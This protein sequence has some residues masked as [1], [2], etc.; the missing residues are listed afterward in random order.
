MIIQIN[1]SWNFA[2]KNWHYAA[3]ILNRARISGFTYFL[4]KPAPIGACFS[5]LY[6][7]QFCITQKSLDSERSWHIQ[8]ETMLS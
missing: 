4:L 8:Y 3:S 6:F 2:D 5:C 7:S 1:S